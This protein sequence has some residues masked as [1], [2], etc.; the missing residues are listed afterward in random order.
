MSLDR[1]KPLLFAIC[2]ALA[3]PFAYAQDEDADSDADPC[4][5]TFPKNIEKDFKKARD[6]HKSGKKS[7]ANEIYRQI[8]DEYPEHLEANYYLGLSYWLPIQ[9]NG[10][11]IERKSDATEVIQ[12]ADRMYDICPTYKIKIHLYAAEA[13]Y[14]IENF[15]AAI[16]HAKVLIENPDLVKDLNDLDMAEMIVSKSKVFAEILNN[17]VPF[18]P[19]P[20]PGISTSDDEYL[21]TLSPDGDFFYFTRRKNVRVQNAFGVSSEDKEFFSCAPKNNSGGYQTGD[22][23]PYPFNQSLGEGSPTINLAN[24]LLI[25]TMMH[26][27]KF[28]NEKGQDEVY[29]N[30]DLYYSVFNGEEWSDPRP[31]GDKVNRKDSWESQPSISSDGNFLFFASDRPGGYGGADIWLTER[32]A[33]GNWQAP[34]N[35][36]P[37]INTKGNERSPF[38]HTDSKTLYFSAA[39]TR[40]GTAGHSGLGGLDIF[41]SKLGDDGKWQKPVNI[42]YPINSENDETDF[43][44]S[45]DGETAY[46]SSN[47]LDSKDWNIYCFELYEAARPKSMILVKGEVKTDDHEM[48]SATVQLLDNESNVVAS[49][50]VNES[51]GKYAL[52]THVSDTAETQKLVLTVKQEG[53]AYDT[54]M[55]TIKK[56]EAKVVTSDAEVKKIEV[57][58]VCELHD[59]YFATNSST[60]TNE[61]KRLINLFADFLFNNPMVKAEIQGH[62]D[63]I[64]NDDDNLRLSEQRAHAV[65]DYLV[66][67]GIPQNRIRYKGYGEGKPIATNSTEEGRAKNRRT[68]FLIYER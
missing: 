6:F 33:N 42:G 43:F 19:K 46:F 44:V 1:L 53:Y 7:E 9:L 35:L 47:N 50:T 34:V 29:P 59:I 64:G 37:T 51:T 52:A 10:L 36:G 21:A 15:P 8:I 63:N 48:A 40:D 14:L 61:S 4:V 5:Q 55:I 39:P 27:V 2:I 49:T 67:K 54:K 26:E 16:K 57:G 30:Y 3:M 24:D 28:K 58:K 13:A 38:L 68:V 25:F 56:E 31:I 65:Y 41:Y 17:P 11:Q 12:A 60:L 32:D 18:D 62:T 45:L 23:L 22:A 66:E 20:V